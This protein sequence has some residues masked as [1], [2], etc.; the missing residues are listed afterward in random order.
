[1]LGWPSFCFSSEVLRFL[2][3]AIGKCLFGFMAQMEVALPFICW[4]WNWISG[5]AGEVTGADQVCIVENSN[6]SAAVVSA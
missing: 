1:M 4:R 3:G 2:T 5:L 6:S